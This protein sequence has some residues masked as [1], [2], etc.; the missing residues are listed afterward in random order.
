MFGK[1]VKVTEKM[2]W[3]ILLKGNYCR[4]LLIWVIFERQYAGCLK[5]ED[6]IE[7]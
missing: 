2:N 1:N 6:C 5:I 4:T 7:K 3:I